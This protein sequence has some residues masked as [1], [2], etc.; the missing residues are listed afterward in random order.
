MGW[1]KGRPHPTRGV[2]RPGTGNRTSFRPGNVPWTAG[3]AGKGVLGPNSGSFGQPGRL[4]GKPLEPVG[5]RRWSSKGAEVDIKVAE[6]SPYAG[7]VYERID[8]HGRRRR[9]RYRARPDAGSWKPLRI[10]NFEAVHG[11]VP[12]GCQVRRLLPICDC[13]SNLVLITPAVGGVLNKGV[14]A[15][16][17]R[18]WAAL[19]L[20]ADVRLSAVI[21]AVAWVEAMRRRRELRVPCL[22]SCGELVAK[23]GPNNSSARD[24]RYVQGHQWRDPEWVRARM[25]RGGG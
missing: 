5:A 24:S 13:E 1:P 7:R 3:L 25:G 22:C 16:P 6:P 19:S 12:R 21:A 11:S 2:K 17:R 9:W 18:P 23:H 10:V 8:K 20:D 4:G 14:W 15:K